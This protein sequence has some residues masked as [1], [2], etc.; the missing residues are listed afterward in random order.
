MARVRISEY[1]RDDAGNLV[2]GDNYQISAYVLGTSTLRT[3]YLDS[4]SVNTVANPHRAA[5]P[6]ES[7][8]NVQAAP[9]D[10]TVTVASTTGWAAGDIIHIVSGSNRAERVIRT[11]TNA[12][13]LLLEAAVGGAFTF[14]S[15]STVR[16]PLGSWQAWVDQDANDSETQLQYVTT[17]EVSN[18]KQWRTATLA[19]AAPDSATYVTMAAEAGLSAEA[20]LGTAV[21]MA[22]T[23][24]ARPAAATAG[25]LYFAT[26]DNGG[27]LYRDTG[28][29]WTQIGVPNNVQGTSIVTTAAE[30]S[31]SAEKVLGTAVIMKGTLAARPAAAIAGLLYW[32]SDDAGGTLY[33][34]TGAAWDKISLG[35]TEAIL[36]SLGTTKGDI[37]AFTASATPARRAVGTDGQVLTADSAQADG[38]KWATPAAGG[39]S[40]LDKVYTAVTVVNTTVETNLYSK[41]I[42]AGSLGTTGGLRLTIYGSHFNNTGAGVTYQFRVKFGATTVLNFQAPTFNASGVRGGWSMDVI[43]LNQGATGSQLGTGRALA[44]IGRQNLNVIAGG[45]DLMSAEAEGTAAE[46][47]TAAKTL[48]VTIQ[49]GTANAL[50]DCKLI[51]AV[52]EQI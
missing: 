39:V 48:A 7:T 37:I 35:L 18:R 34:D 20:V 25:R 47:T 30:A 27:T 22:G 29:A 10:T 11:V 2:G 5:P 50:A 41:S 51:S 46:D 42:A 24:A 26:D 16:S 8:L 28:A 31:L 33:R 6:T 43:L 17:G 15:G 1:A 21:I 38:V 44:V 32:A 52:L 23:L 40:V 49:M 45:T 9:A 13:Q 19:A 14:P 36:K 3:L 4:S 12:T